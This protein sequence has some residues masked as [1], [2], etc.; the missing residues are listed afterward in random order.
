LLD[1]IEKY[2]DDS[3]GVTYH[4]PGG[5]TYKAT[6]KNCAYKSTDDFT[7]RIPSWIQKKIDLLE[8]THFDYRPKILDGFLVKEN[9]LASPLQKFKTNVKEFVEAVQDPALAISI[10][11]HHYALDYWKEPFQYATTRK[12]QT[13]FSFQRLMA[14]FFI[15]GLIVSF[16]GAASC[17]PGVFQNKL[18]SGLGLLTFAISTFS[19]SVACIAAMTKRTFLF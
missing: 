11:E 14:A 18:T 17:I 7:R 2:D 15:A 1:A 16:V 9:L 10:G 8:T 19:S 3:L 4:T 6:L 12:L 13:L 5:S